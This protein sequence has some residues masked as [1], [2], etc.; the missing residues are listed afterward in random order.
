MTPKN[1]RFT[2]ASQI[3]RPMTGTVPNAAKRIPLRRPTLRV[4][5]DPGPLIDPLDQPPDPALVTTWGAAR[6]LRDGVLPWRRI[7]GR[8]VVLVTDQECFER[9]QDALTATFGPLRTA[10]V[11]EGRLQRAVQRLADPTL[12]CDAEKRT[13]DADSCRDLN[14]AQVARWMISIG[15]IALCVA[16]IDPGLLGVILSMIAVLAAL[17]GSILKVVAA[18]RLLRLRPA[19]P[20]PPLPADTPLP[21]MSIMV[22]LFHE[23]QIAEHLLERLRLL[24]YPRDRL[25]VMLVT[26]RDDEVTRATLA[27]TQ[28]PYWMRAITVPPGTCKTKPRALNY[29]LDFARGDI[30]G[31]YDAE[32]APDPDQLLT[33]ARRFAVAPPDVACLQGVLD[34]YN[35]HSNWLARCF[36][37]E[38][39]TWFRVVL[40][41]LESLNLVLPLGGTTLFFR[42]DI[43]EELGAWDAHNV[44]EDADLGIRLARRGY[45]TQM[46]PTTTYEE[47]NARAWPWIKQRSR[48]LKGYAITYWVHMRRPRAL[49]RD[50]GWRR[51]GAFQMQ[52]AGT[53]TT[54]LLTPVLWS[55]WLAM[56][57][58]PHPFMAAIG[59]G[60]VIA[61]TAL[62]LLS[63]VLN[64]SLSALGALRSGRPELMKWAPTLHVYF[65]LAA[66][67]SY[68]AFW[69]LA[70][71]PFYWDKT[72][73]GIFAPTAPPS[74]GAQPTAPQP[75]P[76]QV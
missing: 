65:P 21:V 16:L 6:C 4:V 44:T 17:S 53:L 40:P 48:W 25:D 22:P 76:H 5:P 29:A 69:E 19:P 9:A 15:V 72:A 2:Q 26:E 46:I 54:I 58:V 60:G 23:S 50:L 39:A 8:V 34:F 41:G 42:R 33:V 20:D 66:V 35:A 57:G 74:E 68:K 1:G 14:P 27:R 13:S 3:D 49:L 31:V 32:D 12:V 38:Y 71:R 36:A 73:H 10:H 18:A 56:V 30:I 59:S 11:L 7:G 67:A 51:F 45:Q 47:A 70:T 24:N 61:L 43:L 75:S 37:I 64:I 52:F 63:E 62:F 55:F 28:L